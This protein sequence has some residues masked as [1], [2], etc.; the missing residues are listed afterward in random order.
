MRIRLFCYYSVI[1]TFICCLTI[2]FICGLSK[3]AS[4]LNN[5]C[6]YHQT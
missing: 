5:T 1:D 3:A 6:T 4:V 2:Y